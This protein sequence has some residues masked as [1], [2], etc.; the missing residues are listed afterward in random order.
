LTG[1]SNMIVNIIYAKRY[2]VL[3]FHGLHLARHLKP[4]LYIFS[5][6]IVVSFYT[7]LDT[8]LLGLMRDTSEVGYY[9]A[10]TRVVN[11]VLTVLTA[12]ILVAIPRLS[13]SYNSGDVSVVQLLLRKSFGYIV[14]TAGPAAIGLM[15]EAKDLSML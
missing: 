15:V 7:V 4:L 9:S 2:V 3:R 12:L 8:A 1:V 13:V 6:G 14:L 10:A 5:F 11:L